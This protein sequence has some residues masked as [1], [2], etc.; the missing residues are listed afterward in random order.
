MM[1]F[2]LF[3]LKAHFEVNPRDL[4]N[5]NYWLDVSILVMLSSYHQILC[6][7]LITGVEIPFEQIYWN[8]TRIWA[9]SP[10][11]LT[12]VMCLTTYWTQQLRKPARWSSSLGLQWEVIT[13][14]TAGDL[15]ENLEKVETLLRLSPLRYRYTSL[16]LHTK[17]LI[18]IDSK[19]IDILTPLWFLTYKTYHGKGCWCIWINLVQAPKRDRKGGKKRDGKDSDNNTHKHKKKKTVWIIIWGLHPTLTVLY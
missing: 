3:R 19:M 13:L 11:L 6:E 18:L 8:M 10:Q 1:C 4:G 2:G 7:I 12:S 16:I 5:E 9:R 17:I 14:L 15:R